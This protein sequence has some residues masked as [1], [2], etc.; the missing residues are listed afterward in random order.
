[1]QIFILKKLTFF[2]FNISKNQHKESLAT[3]NR[4]SLRF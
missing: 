2:F 3:F 4:R 1:M